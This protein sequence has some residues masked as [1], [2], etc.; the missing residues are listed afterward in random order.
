MK[1]PAELQ[2][3]ARRSGNESS[4]RFFDLV[5]GFDAGLLS[6]PEA[7]VMDVLGFLCRLHN[8]FT[9]PGGLLVLNGVVARIVSETEDNFLWTLAWARH[10]R[11]QYDCRVGFR[12]T[13]DMSHHGNGLWV[14]RKPPYLGEEPSLRFP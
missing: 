1:S 10:L 7:V 12:A 8:E 9:A 5:V 6:G 3:D 13:G 11:E 4:Q 2:V 14:Q